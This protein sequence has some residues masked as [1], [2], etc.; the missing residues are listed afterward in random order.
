MKKIN[1]FNPPDKPGWREEKAITYLKERK[2]R[3]LQKN[4]SYIENEIAYSLSYSLYSQK[5]YRIL[6]KEDLRKILHSAAKMTNKPIKED[7]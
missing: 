6:S 1:E 3:S 4:T 7:I 2:Q 5:K